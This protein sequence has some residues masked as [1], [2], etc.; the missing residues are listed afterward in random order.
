[1][2]YH[3]ITTDDMNNGSGLRVVLWLSGCEHYCKECQNPQTWDDTSGILFDQNAK[4]ELY[5]KLNKPYISGLTLSGGDPLYDN[6]NEEIIEL[7][8]DVK[9][10]FPQKNIWLYTG[11]SY[12]DIIVDSKKLEI[13]QLCDVLVDGKFEKELLDVNYH[14]AG[15][16]NQRIIDI[17]ESL[18][19]NSIVDYKEM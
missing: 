14:W 12:E 10:I 3:N 17:K 13:L 8:K 1:M 19:T 7:L 15:S 2:N 5:E 11:Y 9:Q 18:L 16:T 4:E 6:N